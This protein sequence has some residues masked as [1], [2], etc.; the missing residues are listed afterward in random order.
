MMV[1]NLRITSSTVVRVDLHSSFQALENE[2]ILEDHQIKIEIGHEKNINKNSVAE[3]AIQELEEELVKISPEGSQVDDLVLAK[4]T[5]QLN[6]KIR[7]TNRSAKELLM[8]RNQF[9]G[10]EIKV[11]DKEILD[12]QF[13]IRRNKNKQKLSRTNKQKEEKTNTAKVQSRKCS[14]C[15]IRQE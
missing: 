5:H 13:E 4:A 6:C 7:H 9:R 15:N 2:E 14:F 3:R 8:K 12:K 10:D 1:Y 11:D